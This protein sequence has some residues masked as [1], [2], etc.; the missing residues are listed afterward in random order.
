MMLDSEEYSGE[1][2]REFMRLD[3]ASPLAYKVCKEETLSKI[4]EGYTVNISEAGLL[5]SLKDKVRLKDV[6]WLSFDK[7]VL[8]T[9]EQIEKRSLIYQNGVIG[10]VVRIDDRDNGT[11]DVGVRFLTREENPP[12]AAA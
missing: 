9:C 11:F 4:L 3:C 10:R 7:S 1:N 6:L 5:C 12:I 8:F 2:R